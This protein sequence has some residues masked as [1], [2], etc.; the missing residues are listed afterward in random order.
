GA[1]LL[2]LTLVALS[3]LVGAL[4]DGLFPQLERDGG[5]DATR[6]L[7]EEALPVAP[8]ASMADLERSA[9]QAKELTARTLAAPADMPAARPLP[10]LDPQARVQTGAGVPNWHWQ[11]VRFD[12]SGPVAG[13]HQIRL[14]L[15][16][17]AGKLG[18]AVAQLLLITALALRLARA[19]ALPWQRPGARPMPPAASA[20][21]LLWGLAGGLATGLL[22]APAPG[23][24][25]D[26]SPAAAFPPPALLDE[27]RTRLLEPPDCLPQCASIGALSLDL[28]EERLHLELSVDA[29]VALALPIP[30]GANAWRPQ[31]IEIDGQ[32]LDALRQDAQGRLL[33]PLPEGRHRLTL[34]APLSGQ[35]GI[36]LPLPLRPQRLSARLAPGWTLEGLDAQGRPA[37][38]LH[39]SRA[40]EADPTQIVEAEGPLTEAAL[41]PLI[42]VRRT[43]RLGL[44]WSIDTEI[45]RLSAPTEALSLRVPLLPGEAV[46]SAERQIDA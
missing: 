1:S 7:Y 13:D 42:E 26:E 21:L 46:T 33:L 5:L 25:T 9:Q 12:W 34:S 23:L 35:S 32:P 38:Q 43:L 10:R 14:W 40:R 45:E 30:G 22:L 3:F 28:D 16:P 36:T 41:A 8:L 44:D 2:I 19:E 4:R 18:L 29:A 27:L 24:A 39:L 20:H 6:G 31:Q 15:L 37:E 11:Q 17:P